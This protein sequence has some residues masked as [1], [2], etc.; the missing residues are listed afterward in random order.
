MPVPPATRHPV[1]SA[2][3]SSRA[4][5]TPVS[6]KHSAIE[7]EHPPSTN[8]NALTFKACGPATLAPHPVFELWQM[9]DN[10][11]GRREELG[12][13]YTAPVA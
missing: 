7:V 6:R 5:I 9:V 8:S 1:E 2:I 4:D 11:N 12:I 10:R 3:P 13:F